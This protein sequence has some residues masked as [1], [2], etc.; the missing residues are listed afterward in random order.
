MKNRPFQ[1]ARLV[2]LL[3]IAGCCQTALHA[4]VPADYK[5]K[6][7]K[8]KVY[9]KGAQTIPGRIELAY[10][11]LGGEGVAYHDTD[12][13]NNGSGKLNR[14]PLHER[15]GIDEYI[16]HFREKEGVDMER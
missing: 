14:E 8:D 2:F 6:P 4:Q 7:F 3:V 10:Y 11:D 16:V 15:P 9:K 5:G 13:I 12:P 1:S